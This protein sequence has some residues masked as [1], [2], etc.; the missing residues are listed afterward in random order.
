MKQIALLPLG[1]II[2]SIYSL[3]FLTKGIFSF[4]FKLFDK[5]NITGTN[6]KVKN[7]A[8]LKPNIIVQL[9]GPQNATLSPPK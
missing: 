3:C 1:A 9:K 2:F 8:K 7:V 5:N 4:V 6:I